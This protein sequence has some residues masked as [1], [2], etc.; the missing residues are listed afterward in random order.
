MRVTLEEV[1]NE[2]SWFYIQPHYKHRNTND[3]VIIGDKLILKSVGP[4][5]PLHASDFSVCIYLTTMNF[6]SH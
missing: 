6:T 4:G 1:G 2:G 5:Q 3:N